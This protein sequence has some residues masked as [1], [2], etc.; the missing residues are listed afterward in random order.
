MTND[1]SGTSDAKDV[2]LGLKVDGDDVGSR[3]ADPDFS[4][5]CN[6]HLNWVNRAKVL[7]R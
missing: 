4:L 2:G 1:E 3:D 7:S 6:P 5:P